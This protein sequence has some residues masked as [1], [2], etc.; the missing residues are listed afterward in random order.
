MNSTALTLRTLAPLGA[1]A[2][3][4][5]PSAPWAACTRAI[6]APVAPTA[7]HIL[8]DGDNASGPYVDFMRHVA[9]SAACSVLMPVMPRP[10]LDRMFFSDRTDILFP[11][12][13]TS[14]RDR[15]GVFVP[16]LIMQPRVVMAKA[17]SEPVQ[18]L[19]S[20]LDSKDWHGV[21]VRGY[22][23]GDRYDA[24]IEELES[25]GRLTQVADLKQVLI[26]L[27]ADRAKFSI[28]P[29]SLLLTP[30][31]AGSRQADVP[32]DLVLHRVADLPPASVGMYLNPRRLSADEID[33]LRRA[34]LQAARS[35]VL[36]ASLRRYYGREAFAMDIS[37]P[38][39]THQRVDLPSQ[40]P[41]AR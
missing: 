30:D 34:A 24:F 39:E 26:M 36:S 6:E 11:A 12:S 21:V 33:P 35:G 14:A 22:H 25:R 31:P 29:S 13:Q 28:L 5:M 2:L 17:R 10:R 23:W 1:I 37:V 41:S 3:A 38:Q 16:W 9:S 20:L 7:R 19:Q 18:S 32:D 27:R 40:G 15:R 4:W 8:I